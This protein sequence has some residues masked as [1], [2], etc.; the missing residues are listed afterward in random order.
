MTEGLFD[1]LMH[2][3][4]AGDKADNSKYPN[5]ELLAAMDLWLGISE[6]SCFRASCSLAS[7]GLEKK[8]KSLVQKEVR[9]DLF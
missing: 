3:M 7:L 9:N 2:L 4:P 8:I 6:S 1:I 5:N